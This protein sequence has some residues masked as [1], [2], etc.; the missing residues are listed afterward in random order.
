MA[1]RSDGGLSIWGAKKHVA[2]EVK[3]ILR[4]MDDRKIF[5]VMGMNKWRETIMA[6]LK[7]GGE[8]QNLFEQWTA[9]G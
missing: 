4:E 8:D 3:M 9:T 5:K 2:K 1:R 6:E 7:K